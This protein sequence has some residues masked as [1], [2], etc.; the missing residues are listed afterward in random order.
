MKKYIL[1]SDLDD[2]LYDETSFVKSGFKEVAHYISAIIEVSESKI[3]SELNSHLRTVGR[4]EVF[5]LTLEKYGFNTK[6]N[7]NNCI[8][9]YR[10]HKPYIRL[11]PGVRK[12]LNNMKNKPYL[13]TDGN[14]SVQKKKVESLKIEENFKKIFYTRAYGIKNEKPSLHCFKKISQIENV[15]F[16]NLIYIGDN[17]SKDF[18]N[19]NRFGALTIKV[20]NK[21]DSV[22]SKE[23]K[24]QMNFDNFTDAISYLNNKN[25]I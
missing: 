21:D 22:F 6:K 15:S 25:L 1:C 24:A 7:I 14:T 19:L 11:Y 18:L 13:V 12:V 20:G 3:F 4:G 16:E 23:Y 5:D 2:T 9:V 10:K 8:Q 17:T